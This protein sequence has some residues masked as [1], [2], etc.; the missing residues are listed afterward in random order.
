MFLAGCGAVAAQV[1]LGRMHDRQVAA[2]DP[3]AKARFDA[4]ARGP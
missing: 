3:A 1:L 4:S 2:L